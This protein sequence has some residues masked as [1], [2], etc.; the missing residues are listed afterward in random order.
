LQQSG[1][2]FRHPAIDS[3]NSTWAGK[4]ALN[5]ATV[6]KLS[7]PSNYDLGTPIFNQDFRVTKEFVV[8][9]RCRF[10]L[11]V[12]AMGVVLALTPPYAMAADRGGHGGG[13]FRGGGM[14]Q[15]ARG[16]SGGRAFSGREG[17]F[18][19]RGGERHFDRDRDYHFHGGYFYGAPGFSV[20]L[21]GAPYSYG[22][23]YACGYYNQGGKWI[24]T[25]GCHPY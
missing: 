3:F 18:D 13:G 2:E 15:S 9:E 6:P 25:P 11:P 21:Y 19:G 17:H 24:P 22:P 12:L 5:G 7:L 16:F 23:G 20:G 10:M 8:K 1:L 14:N 4:K